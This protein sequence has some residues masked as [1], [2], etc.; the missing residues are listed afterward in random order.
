[1]LLAFIHSFNELASCMGPTAYH[2][3]ARCVFISLIHFISVCLDCATIASNKFS[4]GFS[5]TGTNIIM[6]V[7]NLLR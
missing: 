7:Y 1:M 2:P 5:A 4:G 3:F 6:E